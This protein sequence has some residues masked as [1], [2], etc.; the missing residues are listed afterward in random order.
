MTTSPST[1]DYT[2]GSSK[3]YSRRTYSLCKV[4]APCG[5]PCIL[6]GTIRHYYHSCNKLSCPMCHA[7][8]RFIRR[9]K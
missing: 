4:K 3:A 9:A 8:E 6:N 2:P 1:F 7:P 5:N